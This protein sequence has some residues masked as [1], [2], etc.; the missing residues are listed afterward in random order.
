MSNLEI[1]R[2]KRLDQRVIELIPE[3]SRAFATKLI[4]EGKVTVDDTKVLKAGYKLRGNESENV[5]VDYDMADVANIPVIDLEVLYEDD[6]CVII[7]KPLGVLTH[8][9]GL[10]N[11]EAT[12][13]TWLR[14]R[15]G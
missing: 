12:V 3:L 6:D 5:R 14:S 4:E 2:A 11:A 9:K 15:T 7:N 10:F 13:E 1:S 8:S